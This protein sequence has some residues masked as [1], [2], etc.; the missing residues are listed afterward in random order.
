MKRLLPILGIFLITTLLGCSQNSQ[1]EKEKPLEEKN[2]LSSDVNAEPFTFYSLTQYVD[3]FENSTTWKLGIFSKNKMLYDSPILNTSPVLKWQI[4]KKKDYKTRAQLKLTCKKYLDNYKSREYELTL[5]PSAT[6]TNNGKVEIKF[7][8]LPPFFQNLSNVKRTFNE[9]SFGYNSVDLIKR[10]YEH[11][12]LKIRYQTTK[13]TQIPEF[14]LDTKKENSF[15]ED[16]SK[17][18]RKC[19]DNDHKRDENHTDILDE[20]IKGNIELKDGKFKRIK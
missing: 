17:F 5:E 9:L 8:N 15:F 1:R 10:L 2:T 18:V 14:E 13:G 4:E 6:I 7:D 11:S 19:N 3:D 20:V 16:K 12:T